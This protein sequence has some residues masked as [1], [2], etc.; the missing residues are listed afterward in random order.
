[1]PS[2]ETPSLETPSLETPMITCRHAFLTLAIALWSVE[3]FAQTAPQIGY[4]FPAGGQR[5]TTVDVHVDCKYM[6]G[7]C[8][9]WIGGTGVTS[10]AK[11]TEGRLQLT[12]S[13]DAA[14]G[15]RLMR[16]FSVQGASAPRPFVVGELPEVL[17][18]AGED[19]AQ[20]TFPVTVNGQLNPQG[21]IDQFD[22]SLKAGQQIVC[23]VAARSFGSPCDTTLRLLD[24]AGR[25]VAIS[26]DHR[27]LDALLVYRCAM[28]GN[29]TLQLYNYDLS[30]RPEHVYRL[31]VTDGPYLDY[32]FP[33]GMQR[34]TKSTITLSGWN[35]TDGNSASYSVTPE[36]AG[37]SCEITLPGCANR[38]TVPVG[39]L[40]ERMETEPN[41]SVESAQAVALPLTLNGRFET[42]GDVDVFQFTAT[43][44]QK[45]KFD[46]V[47][48]SLG[49][50]TDAVLTVSND[51]GKV[52]KTIDDVSGTADPS[53]LFTAPADGD[54]FVALTE[55]A[56]RG[57]VD[58]IYR[59]QIAEPRPDLR[60]TVKASEY[61]IE[62]G[63]ELEIPVTLT[64]FDGFAIEFELTAIDLPTGVTVEPQNIPAKSPASAKLKF[65]AAEG[66]PFPAS[67]IRI[68]ARF[69]QNDQPIERFAGAAVAA[70]AGSAPSRTEK[71]WLAVRP[72]IPFSLATTTV[73]LEANRMAAFRFPVTAVRD[74]GFTGLIRLVGVDPDRRGT[75]VPLSGVIDQDSNAGSIPLIIQKKAVEG[76]THRSRVMGVVDV[77]GP[78]GKK[79]PVFHVSKGSMAMGCQ[80]NLLTLAVAPNR[81]TRHAGAFIEVSV[82]VVRRTTMSDVTI[83]A[84]IPG[85]AD[86]LQFKPVTLSA[87]RSRV[88][89][90]LRL[91]EGVPLPP[92]VTLELR[93]ESSRD[94]LPVS[95]TTT[96]TMVAP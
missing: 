35:L 36:A 49:F 77:F 72:H 55:R 85:Y 19:A 31:T 92:R 16:I 26:N 57:H 87:D 7:P 61:A 43:K 10:P 66:L 3:A 74:E 93:A 64:K 20:I 48:A 22:L 60:L 52:L 86:S 45:M 76:T 25:V 18:H 83:S 11:T 67:P 44:A 53:L 37:T 94:G 79:H 56:V 14:P 13:K 34:G 42:S 15:S 68:V 82:T 1:L 4:L 27:G 47:A 9:V 69:K 2:L 95:A 81:V 75:V 30:G 91:E 63:G 32:A 96:L 17:E 89:L 84:T 38:L 59:L 88:T 41:N 50:P 46:V 90:T 12:I 80:P 71:L 58:F 21:D 8:G 33:S 39:H 40:T 29:F 28:V 73:I 65:H 78:D 23:A 54:Y 5:G 51:Q 24:S 6:P 70:V 62:S